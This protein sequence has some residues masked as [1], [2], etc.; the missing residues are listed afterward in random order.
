MTQS[1]GKLHVNTTLYSINKS[2]IPLYISSKI[3]QLGELKDVNPKI[4]GSNPLCANIFFLPTK[5]ACWHTS[6]PA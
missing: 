6:L 4:A 3:A 1:R 2:Q 5:F